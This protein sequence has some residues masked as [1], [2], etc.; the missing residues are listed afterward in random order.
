MLTVVPFQFIDL[1]S[2]NPRSDSVNPWRE[3]LYV[4]HSVD[5]WFKIWHALRTSLKY[6]VLNGIQRYM[7]NYVS[8]GTLRLQSRLSV[9]LPWT[10][11]VGADHRRFGLVLSSAHD[12]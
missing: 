9:R 12:A 6:F 10:V 2:K 4:D 3:R 1:K 5:A 11:E 8:A 7:S